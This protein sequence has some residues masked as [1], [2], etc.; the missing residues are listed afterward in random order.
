MILYALQEK[1]TLP[2]WRTLLFSIL[3]IILFYM[4][5]SE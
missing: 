2:K 3:L 5:M 4:K 1:L